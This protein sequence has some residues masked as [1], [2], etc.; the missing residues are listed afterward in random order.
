MLGSGGIHLP[1]YSEGRS[2]QISVKFQASLLYRAS[3]RIA[4]RNPVSRGEKKKEPR[5]NQNYKF[6]AG[7]QLSG[8]EHQFAQ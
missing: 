7:M 6:R 5:P 1:K 4:Q 2:R 3:S 8:R